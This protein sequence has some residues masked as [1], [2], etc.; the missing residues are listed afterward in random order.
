MRRGV[1]VGVRLPHGIVE[2]LDAL[3]ARTGG[4]LSRAGVAHAAV[5]LGL[6]ALEADPSRMFE[7]ED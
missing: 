2:R 1:Q 7:P 3:A 6:A 4:V 5:R